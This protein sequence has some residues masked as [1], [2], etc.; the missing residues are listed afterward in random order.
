MWNLKQ[1]Q[2]QWVKYLTATGCGQERPVAT[3]TRNTPGDGSGSVQG[4]GSGQGGS[5]LESKEKE[6]GEVAAKSAKPKRVLTRQDGFVHFWFCHLNSQERVLII[7]QLEGCN[8]SN[9][10][11]HYD[12]KI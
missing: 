7:L 11:S 4:A 8:I 9:V 2:A 1:F 10:D 12:L 3:P 5:D 6:P